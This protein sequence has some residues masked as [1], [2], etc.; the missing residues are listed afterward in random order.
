MTIP[1]ITPQHMRHIEQ[2]YLAQAALSDVLIRRAAAALVQ[3][4]VQ[5]WPKSSRMLLY[6]GPG[7]NGADALAM[8][9]HLITQGWQVSFLLWRR[10]HDVW[11]ERACD[12]GAVLLDYASLKHTV[13]ECD[14][15]VDGLLGIGVNRPLTAE[16]VDLIDTINQR[17]SHVTCVSIDVPSGVDAD[18]GAIWGVCVNADVTLSTGPIKSGVLLLPALQYA[19]ELYAL[20]LGL[21]LRDVSAFV[22][23]VDVVRMLLPPRPLD[24]YKGTYGTL[25]VWAGSANYPGAA[26]LSSTAAARSGAGIVSLAT[27]RDI[28]P[29]VWQTPELTLTLLDDSPLTALVDARFDAYVIGPGLG[30]SVETEALLTTFLNRL[31]LAH[32]T[33]VIDADALTLLSRHTHWYRQLPPNQAVLTPHLGELTRLCGGILPDMPLL[34]LARECAARWQQTLVIKGS[35]TVIAASDGRAF[36]WPHPN[37]VLA[38]AGS[39]D[40][41]AGITGA[42]LAQGCDPFVAATIAVYLQGAIAADFAKSHG[43]AGVLASDIV[44]AIPQ[45]QHKIRSQS[46]S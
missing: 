26:V 5:H 29:L 8:V 22:L 40:V 1:I 30:R 33:C 21:D 15:I 2:D 28:V 25:C 11:V 44:A 46:T 19:G 37:P 16:I 27:M 24:S 34:Q 42:M 13:A 18:T 10:A 23:T 12:A 3:H 32:R 14:V 17:P 38:T 20:D 7:N 41:L 45:A 6:V 43:L 39:G 4:I 36:V 9:P 31:H 35:T